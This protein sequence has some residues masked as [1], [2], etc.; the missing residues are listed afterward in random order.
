MTLPPRS[1]SAAAPKP[2]VA[3][4][5]P[6]V[7]SPPPAPDPVAVAITVPE[8]KQPAAQGASGP[9]FVTCWDCESPNPSDRIF[10]TECGSFIAVGSKVFSGGAYPGDAVALPATPGGAMSLGSYAVAMRRQAARR[11]TL[12]GAASV[13]LVA[14]VG[15]ASI[16]VATSPSDHSA[17][18]PAILAAGTEEPVT[19]VPEPTDEAMGV[20]AAV[21]QIPEI[22]LEEAPDPVALEEAP[23]QEEPAPEEELV[24]EA[25]VQEEPVLEEELV[26]EA[27][28][29]EVEAAVGEAA[30]EEGVAAAEPEEAMVELPAI[31]EPDVVAEPAAEAEPGPLVE[32]I[33]EPAVLPLVE[34]DEPEPEPEFVPA[35]ESDPAPPTVTPVDDEAVV[36]RDGWVCDG[37]LQLQ[38][39]RLRDWT[40]TRVSFLPGD[41]YERVVLHVNR[42]GSGSGQPASVAVEAFPTARVAREVPGVRQPS[43]GRTTVALQFQDG[44]KTDVTLR[45]YKPTGLRTVKQFSAYPAGRSAARVLVSAA[46]DGCFKV[47]APA[48]SSRTGQ[49]QIH[50]DIKS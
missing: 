38:D 9:P 6:P 14:I 46:A 12:M 30:L 13:A 41:G 42:F 25:P 44:L 18:A 35:G 27:P 4:P 16:Y 43:S 40:I 2:P 48:W 21:V 20:A 3:S 28:A 37:Q 26:P 34:P 47:R 5:P 1:A 33:E 31:V 50:I 49:G 15:L 10:C 11:R 7:A 39:E 36:W 29:S 32:P 22:E 17:P 45:N 19:A 24:P 8:G 23:A